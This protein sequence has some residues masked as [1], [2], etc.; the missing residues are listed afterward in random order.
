MLRREAKGHGGGEFI[1]SFHLPIK[2]GFSI[3]TK[4]VCPADSSPQ[5]FDSQLAQPLNSC[6]E[7]VIFEVEPLANP[8]AFREA[9]D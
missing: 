5:I 3:G 7:T 9:L 1:Q 6:R 8:Q 4:P 2:P